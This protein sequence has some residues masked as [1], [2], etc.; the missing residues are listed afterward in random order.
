MAEPTPVRGERPRDLVPA[1]AAAAT[2]RS[3]YPAD[4]PRCRR[5]VDALLSLTGA[6][7]AGGREEVTLLRVD[8]ELVVDGERMRGAIHGHGLVRT[9]DRP[10]IERLT[11]RAGVGA[12]ELDALLATLAGARRAEGTDHVVLGRVRAGARGEG[13]DDEATD[14]AATRGG[15]DGADVDDLQAGL[16]LLRA[17]LSA[18]FARLDR[19]LWQ[20]V[21]ATARES[22]PLVLLGEMRSVH[23]RLFR[24]AAVVSLWTLGF[25]RALN[26]D[27][28]LLHDL[29][30]A[31][32][33]HDVGLLNVPQE[34]VFGRGPRSAEERRLLRRHPRLGAIRLCAVPDIPALPVVVAHEHHLRYDGRGGYPQLGR[35]PALAARLVAVVDTWDMIYGAT[36]GQPLALRRRHTRQA[37]RARAGTWLDPVLVERFLELLPASG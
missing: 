32:L 9:L 18:G 30:L 12:E 7:F 34:V 2:A 25:A 14:A 35:R 3:L 11:L 24:H 27:E 1:L 8:D 26:L 17:D 28:G 16:D 5:A 10:G 21:E 31:G 4:H 6:L 23:D 15:L 19:L 33:L 20:L 29:A 22:R 37:L 13:A 36:A